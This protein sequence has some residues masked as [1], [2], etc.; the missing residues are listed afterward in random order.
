MDNLVSL[1]YQGQREVMGD[2]ELLV[3]KDHR[4][5][6]VI[7][8]QMVH[9]GLLVMMEN[10]ETGVHL[11]LKVKRVSLEFKAAQDLEDLQELRDLK[12]TQEHLASLAIQENKDLEE[13]KESLV[14]LATMEGKVTEASRATRGLL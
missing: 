8:V 2:L 1:V 10:M 6:R 3:Q 9:L 5:T 11:V 12:V 13:S 4:E 7:L 14:T